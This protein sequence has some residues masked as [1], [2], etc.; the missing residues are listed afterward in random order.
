MIN[1]NK[2]QDKFDEGGFLATQYLI[3]K[4]HKKIGCLT[5]IDKHISNQ[6]FLGFKSD[7]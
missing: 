7:A 6:R 4:G 1:F 5:G 3:N 2:I